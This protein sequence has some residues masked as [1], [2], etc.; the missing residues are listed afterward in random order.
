MS[1]T[2]LPTILFAK[3]GP[4]PLTIPLPKYL[5]IPSV[6]VGGTVRRTVAFICNPCSLSRTHAPSAVSHS[7]AQTDGE[8]PTTVTRSRWPVAFTR[9]T[10]K[11]ESSLKIEE[12]HAF[13]EARDPLRMCLGGRRRV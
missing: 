10:Q 2:N 9:R 6:V 8:D 11:P 7:P 5:S 13:D 12:G 3:T 4:I 1:K